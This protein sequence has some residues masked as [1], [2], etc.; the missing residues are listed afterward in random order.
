MGTPAALGSKTL[1]ELLTGEVHEKSVLPS[2]SAELVH[3][4]N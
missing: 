3:R 1:T 2:I 4:N